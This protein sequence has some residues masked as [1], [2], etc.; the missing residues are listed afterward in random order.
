MKKIMIVIGLLIIII[1]SCIIFLN[2]RELSVQKITNKKK[3]VPETEIKALM[4]KQKDDEISDKNVNV[5][6]SSAG[7][8]E[9]KD[10]KQ[11]IENK[12]EKTETK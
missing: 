6:I 5:N 3:V 4:K 2:H 10:N 11:N 8:Q 7:I 12:T 9:Q 1:F